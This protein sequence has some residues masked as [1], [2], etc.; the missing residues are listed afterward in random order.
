MLESNGKIKTGSIILNDV[1]L[2]DPKETKILLR[3]YIVMIENLIKKLEQKL[4]LYLVE[5][6]RK[7][8]HFLKKE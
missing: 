8:Q 1:E 7:A 2:K 4:M 3:I 5:K 6:K